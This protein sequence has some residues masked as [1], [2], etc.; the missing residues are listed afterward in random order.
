MD[1]KEW[2]SIDDKKWMAYIKGM[3]FQISL[4]NDL[5]KGD[6]Y[7]LDEMSCVFTYSDSADDSYEFKRVI[8]RFRELEPCMTVAETIATQRP[9]L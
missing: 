4:R 5:L 2:I 3:A 7:R 9:A 6:F 8:A 1:T